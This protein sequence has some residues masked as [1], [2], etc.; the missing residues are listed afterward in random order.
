MLDEFQRIEVIAG[1]VLPVNGRAE[2]V[3]YRGDL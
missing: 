2:I 1:A 3:D